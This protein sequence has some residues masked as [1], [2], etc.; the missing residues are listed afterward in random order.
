MPNN[1]NFDIK[2]IIDLRMKLH[3]MPEL[4]G[5]EYKTS[6]EITKFIAKF[7]PTQIIEISKTGKAFVFDS[8][9]NGFTTM[10]RVEM[11]ALPINEPDEIFNK[12]LI[13]DVSHK[14][15]HDGHMAILAGLAEAIKNNPPDTGKVVLLFQPAEET[16]N[17]A[18]DVVSDG[19]FKKIK[20]DYI[21]GLHNLPGFEENSVIIR[22][23]NFTSVTTGVTINLS[24]NTSHSSSPE[25]A[26]NPT[27]AVTTLLKIFEKITKEKNFK[28]LVLITPIFIQVGSPNYGITPGDAEI[29]LAISAYEYSDLDKL[30]EVIQE[31]VE[32]VASVKKLKQKITYTADAPPIQN[33]KQAVIAVKEA[34]FENDLLVIE[35]K[36]PFKWADGFGYYTIKHKG[37]FFGFGAGNI[38]NLYTKEFQFNDNIMHSAIKLLYSI[39]KQTNK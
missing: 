11:D 24:G 36:V 26:N 21:F 34:A 37:A 10:F 5:K 6:E 39:Y 18:Y 15:G 25:N 16:L 33:A 27:T 14:C 1:I 23:G 28:D 19:A 20:P 38:S 12:S 31:K 3:R 22:E 35:P 30:I 7:K 32:A 9:K 4:S 8:K 29:K 17:G 13:K 2:K